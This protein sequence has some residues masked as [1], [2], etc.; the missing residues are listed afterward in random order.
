MTAVDVDSVIVHP[1]IAVPISDG[2]LQYVKKE[3]ADSLQNLWEKAGTDILDLSRASAATRRCGRT[4]SSLTLGV[5]P[6]TSGPLAGRDWGL[7][8][9]D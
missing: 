5:T 6:L 7:S 1:L 9:A 3:G 8:Y 4:W 2:E